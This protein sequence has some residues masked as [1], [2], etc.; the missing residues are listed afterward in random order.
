[1]YP[2]I[3]RANTMTMGFFT[4]VSKGSDKRVYLT[5][6]ASVLVLHVILNMKKIAE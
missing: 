1:M 2:L 6:A 5:A 4:A 3:K